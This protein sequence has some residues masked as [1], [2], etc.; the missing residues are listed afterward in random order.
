M[1][2][3]RR[4]LGRQKVRYNSDNDDNPLVYQ[5]IVDDAKVTPTS[6]TIAIYKPGS[7]TAV[8]AATAMTKSG[9]L[10][11]YTVNT[12]TVANFPVD[13][14]YRADIV[15]TYN[16]LTYNRHIVFD[17]AKYLFVPDLA[18][19]QLVALDDGIRGMQHD[20]DDDFS[21]LI[22]ACQDVLQARIESK[23]LE[24]ERLLNELILDASRVSTAFRFLCLHQI[25]FNKGDQDRA[26]KYEERYEEMLEAVL[27]TMQYDSSQDG[28]EDSKIGGLT[29]TRLVT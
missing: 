2:Y 25:W 10:L 27:S 20:G 19:D 13:Q 17:V 5:L 1:A 3:E 23:V 11:T 24:D 8:L 14:G 4:R 21:E 26:D 18:F 9:S 22:G 16:A 7:T 28:E 15:V 29:D 12:T 6:A